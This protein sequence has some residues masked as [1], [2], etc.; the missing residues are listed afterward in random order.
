MASNETT[1]APVPQ[2][3]GEGRKANVVH[4]DNHTSAASIHGEDLKG[5]DVTP[6]VKGGDLASRWLETYTGPRPELTDVLS[7][8]VG[9]KVS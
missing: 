2:A 6:G 1:I 5:A 9:R 4:T 7:E 3:D 8:K